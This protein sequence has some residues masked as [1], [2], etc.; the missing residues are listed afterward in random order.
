MSINCLDV[1]FSFSVVILGLLHVCAV[2]H[3]TAATDL[4]RTR[5]SLDE[6]NLLHKEL[7]IVIVNLVSLR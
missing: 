4:S 7:L 5:A 3:T 2:Q 1:D 6:D